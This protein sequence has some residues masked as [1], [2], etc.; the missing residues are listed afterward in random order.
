M[1]KFFTLIAVACTFVLTAKAQFSEN[2]DNDIT[3]LSANCWQFSNITWTNSSPNINGGT[4]YGVTTGDVTTP[5]LNITSTSVTISFKYQLS[6]SLNGPAVR[7][8]DIGLVDMLGS[9]SSL[10][11]IS[12]NNSSPTTVQNFS[13]SY[14]LS[15]TCVKKLKITIGGSGGSVKVLIDELS[16]SA[17]AKYGPIFHC[18][19]A[20]N[21]AKDTFF[22]TSGMTGYGNV[23]TNDVEPDGENMTAVVLTPSPDG[24]VIMNANGSFSFT[25][26]VGFTGTTT[27]FVYQ[28][29]DDGYASTC[30]ATTVKIYFVEAAPL[31]VKLTKFQGNKNGD[32]VSLQWTV[33][34]NEI[35]DRFEVERSV[36]GRDFSTAALVFAS[37]KYGDESYS[38]NETISA[39]IIYYRL[40]MYDKNHVAEYSKILVFRSKSATGN[41]IRIINNPVKDKLTISFSSSLN[42]AVDMKVYDVNGRMLMAQKLTVY[43]GSNLVSIPLS[44]SFKTGFYVVEINNGTESQTAKFIKQ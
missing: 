16:T 13:N 23:M 38:F 37:E 32:K 21:P 30:A 19:S 11:T 27:N 36:N 9:Y 26:N 15:S 34:T 6:G 3:S 24:T 1:K 17:S 2:F 31:P 14:T 7:T 43:E 28:V 25:P 39:D 22:F 35:V 33:A 42:Q 41:A 29:C 8:I 10:Q 20:P 12:L 40:K 4:I 18:N 5:F 44:S